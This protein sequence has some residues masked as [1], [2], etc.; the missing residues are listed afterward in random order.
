M[1]SLWGDSL[2]IKEKKRHMKCTFESLWYVHVHIHKFIS[3]IAVAK[4]TK[5]PHKQ[6]L[7]CLLL[8][9]H[10]YISAYYN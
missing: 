2:N 4:F 7:Y 5:E 6:S 8:K 3:K 1:F 9:S 10:N